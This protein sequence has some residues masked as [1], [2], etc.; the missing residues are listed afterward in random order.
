LDSVKE[1]NAQLTEKQKE[2]H[3][4]LSKLGRAIDKVGHPISYI[5]M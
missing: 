4:G 5:S 3:G 2:W 1:A